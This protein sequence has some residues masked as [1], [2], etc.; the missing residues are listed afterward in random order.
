MIDEIQYAPELFSHIK[1]YVDKNQCAGDFWMTGS[2]LFKLMED[3]Q[4]SLAG[5]VALLHLSSFSQ[6]EVYSKQVGAF[7]LSVDALAERQRATT[8]APAPEVFERIFLG[9]MPALVSKNIGSAIF[10]TPAISIPI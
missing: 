5:R 6:Q 3:V 1:I 9:G 10:S 2:Q 8:P 4:E 7:T